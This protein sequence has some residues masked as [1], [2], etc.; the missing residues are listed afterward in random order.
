MIVA[1]QM[2]FIDDRASPFCIGAVTFFQN[3]T[4]FA[5][6]VTMIIAFC[7]FFIKKNNRLVNTGVKR[8]HILNISDSV[9]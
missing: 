1:C 4:S 5:P 9:F 3:A 7:I 6:D 8:G 2:C